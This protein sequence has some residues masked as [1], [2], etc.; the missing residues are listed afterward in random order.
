MAGP[1]D[2][3]VRQLVLE[4]LAPPASGDGDPASTDM[5]AALGARGA[6]PIMT[7]LLASM[8][9]RQAEPGR[10]DEQTEAEE[11][12]ERARAVI[13]KLKRD[14]A[15]AETMARYIAGTFGACPSCW[16]LSRTCPQCQGRGGPGFTEPNEEE[17]LAWVG[18]ALRRLGLEV[19]RQEGGTP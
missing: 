15:T 8:L 2:D 14:L 6:D 17:L 18:P 4:R 3:A 13:R 19:A 10:V 16:G 1:I 7:A 12:L 9:N 5:A 11:K